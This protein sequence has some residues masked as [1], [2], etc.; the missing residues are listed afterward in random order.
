MSHSRLSSPAL[1][2]T[3]LCSNFG[4]RVCYYLLSFRDEEVETVMVLVAC[5]RSPNLVLEADHYH[6]D[7]GFS[8]VK[9]HSL[10]VHLLV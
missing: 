9:P 1:L 8:T 6:S 3:F 2:G 4:R 7:C 10:C 5:A